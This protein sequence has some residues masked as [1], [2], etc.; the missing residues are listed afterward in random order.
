MTE[1]NHRDLE[2]GIYD[3]DSEE[4]PP[5]FL[6]IIMSNVKIILRK[7]CA[8]ICP[9]IWRFDPL[10]VVREDASA[11]SSTGG[12]ISSWAAAYPVKG[13]REGRKRLKWKRVI[14]YGG[15]TTTSRD[16]AANQQYH[17]Y[18]NL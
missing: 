18:Y 11:W 1:E 13:R 10:L 2:Q 15:D 16:G 17:S 14:D 8:N 7:L 6:H 4:E 12:V 5:V 3:D 9:N